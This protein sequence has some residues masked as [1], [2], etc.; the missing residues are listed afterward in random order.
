MD[1]IIREDRSLFLW[2]NR[3]GSEPFDNFW[4]MVSDKWIWIPLYV[5]LLYL[6]YKNYSRKALFYVVIFIGLGVA[7]S[8]QISG[9]F[10]DGIARLR[11][12]H[13]P[14][15]EGVMRKVRCGGSYGFYS[16]HASNTFF[17][18]MFVARMLYRR[19]RGMGRLL[20]LWAAVVSYSRIYLG[21]HFPLDVF[22]G[23]TVGVLLGGFFSTLAL[24]TI[25]KTNA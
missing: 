8:D 15:L 21:V 13:D 1:E 19:V 18:A 7:A 20:F 24:N 12:C 23:A 3:L 14:L 11:P 2:L 9:I 6:I 5:I 10:K 17:I 16:A 4:I 25:R 22:F